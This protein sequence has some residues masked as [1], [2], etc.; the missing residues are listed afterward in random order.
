MASAVRSF[1][2][3]ISA[4][5]RFVAFK[6]T[7]TTSGVTRTNLYQH[8]LQTSNTTLIA[9]NVWVEG[10]PEMT[11]DG[12]YV[13]Y[14]SRTDLFRWDSATG[15]SLLVNVD[16]TGTNTAN[17]ISYRPVISP[18]GSKI[19]FLSDADNLTTN[20]GNGQ[21]QI[22]VRDLTQGTTRLVSVRQDGQP[23][24]SAS[25]VFPT[26]S[27]DGNWV[28]FWSVDE[29]FVSHDNNR[30]A[31]V[32]LR[33]INGET[34]SLISTHVANLP[35]QTSAGYFLLSD[36]SVSAD[37]RFAVLSALGSSLVN[38]E[39][40]SLPH[41]VE[42]DI[43]TGINTPVDLLENT[44]GVSAPGNT[45]FPT[46]L[47][48]RFPVLSANGRYVAY[49]GKVIS[50]DPSFNHVYVRDLQSQTNW[51]AS[52][53]WNG[54]GV[55]PSNSSLPSISGDGMRVAFQSDS[56]NL[57]PID[58]NG[59]SDVFVYDVKAGSNILVSV[60][61]SGT[62]SGNGP[63]TNPVISKDGRWVA[64][65]SKAKD[66]GSTVNGFYFQLFARD[67]TLNTTKLVSALANGSAFTGDSGS[68][69]LNPGGNLILFTNGNNVFLGNLT[70]QTNSLVCS[71]CFNPSMSASGRWVVYESVSASIKDVF[72]KD[73]QTGI[74]TLI[75]ANVSGTGGGNR[76]STK[77]IISFD[78]RYIVFASRA[79][80]LVVNDTNGMTD[81]FIRD[82]ILNTTI[83][84]SV[85]RQGT[86]SANG[87]S[88][89]PKLGADGRT[90]IFQSFASNLIDQDFNNNR[91]IFVLRLSAGDSDN[92]DLD[93]DWEFAYFGTLAR[94]GTEDFDGDGHTDAEEFALGTDPTNLGS[95]LR[96]VT[97]SRV[98]GNTTVLWS[99]TPGKKY[100]VQFKTGIGD[101]GWTDLGGVVIAGNSTAMQ[102]DVS[103]PQKIAI[104]ASCLFHKP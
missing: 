101:P 83:L 49:V 77:P 34:T 31:D 67:L 28:A 65:Q 74:A 56:P 42:H 68:P 81:I 58:A 98:G 52:R 46:N 79:T 73:L 5:G 93:D 22:Y 3:D 51:R 15:S 88:S 17:G 1:N 40:N 60:K 8:D 50:D 78:G 90:V 72:V 70:A 82:R 19:A 104:T 12:R 54:A 10:F 29:K 99:A 86:G 35:S 69:I 33:D 18:D 91:D 2:P 89:S 55:S 44:N 24:S 25:G 21:P 32:F 45:L 103:V 102:V 66:L 76:S 96:V 84:A 95:V 85:N 53:P 41:I 47:N 97:V 13:A 61:A 9:S 4:D 71:S 87:I 23:G 80:N 48:A 63:S 26:L 27:A 62:G 30:D 38:G 75:S 57:V 36:N 100:Q 92:D 59:T 7:L 20:G 6:S 11:P 64:F 43:A 37:G 39:S 94:D 14:E 16:L